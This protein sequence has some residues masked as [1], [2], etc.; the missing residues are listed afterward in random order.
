MGFWDARV[1][2]EGSDIA[3]DEVESGFG[4]LWDVDAEIKCGL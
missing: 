4:I 3:S 2:V 1:D